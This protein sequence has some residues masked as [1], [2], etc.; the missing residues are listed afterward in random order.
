MGNTSPVKL[1]VEI[2][3]VKTA[4]GKLMIGI[5]KPDDKF[6]EG[7]PGFSEIIEVK[8]AGSQKAFFELEPGKYALAVYHDLNNNG[9]L[10]KNFV[11]IPKEPYGFSKD[12]R[13]KFS[14]PSFEDCTFEVTSEAAQKIAVRLTN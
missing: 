13:P 7:K 6:G 8:S 5:Y 9:E 2:T 10:D 3:N 1:Q 11:G 4:K 12:F 14:A